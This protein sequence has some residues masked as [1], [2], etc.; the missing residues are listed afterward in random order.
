TEYQPVHYEMND[1]ITERAEKYFQ[2]ALIELLDVPDLH[3]RVLA[4]EAAR[5]KHEEP[6]VDRLRELGLDD[7]RLSVV[8]I[9]SPN[10][11]RAL[12]TIFEKAL[13]NIAEEDH[14]WFDITH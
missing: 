7:R 9:E 14:V 13:E 4:T 1:R 2:A 11:E 10:S 5:K 3:V 8:D 6:L 12:W